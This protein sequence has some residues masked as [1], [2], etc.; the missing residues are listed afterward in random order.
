MLLSRSNGIQGGEKDESESER[1]R[2]MSI[3][4][5]LYRE[6]IIE[7]NEYSYSACFYR[8]SQLRARM[9]NL[10]VG[11]VRP[12]SRVHVCFPSVNLLVGKMIH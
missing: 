11:R 9:Q 1:E 12:S 10:L 7:A 5:L 4:L 8:E 2:E 6:L 3:L